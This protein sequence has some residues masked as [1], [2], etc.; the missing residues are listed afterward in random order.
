MLSSKVMTETP[1]A[2]HTSR[3]LE[4]PTSAKFRTPA[5]VDGRWSVH[6]EDNRSNSRLKYQ[7]S[8]AQTR[9]LDTSI[10]NN[11]LPYNDKEWRYEDSQS[12][13][14]KLFGE[15][16]DRKKY[17]SKI[18]GKDE[19]EKRLAYANSQIRCGKLEL[20]VHRHEIE[21]GVWLFYT[22][23]TGFVPNIRHALWKFQL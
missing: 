15:V 3:T 19:F 4:F 10:S 22:A 11:I 2:T 23:K 14:A 18:L 7:Q 13:S 1:S 21:V 8:A 6:K 16:I 12:T 9:L 5:S 17:D 20:R